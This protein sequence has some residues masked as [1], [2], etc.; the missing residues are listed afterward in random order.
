MTVKRRV[1]AVV[2]ALTMC[3]SLVAGLAPS[4]AAAEHDS[5]C[6]SFEI[7]FYYNSNLGGAKHDYR[8]RISNFAG[9]NFLS[10]GAGAGQ[11]VKNNAASARNYDGYFTA[12]VY[13]N[14]G[15][16]GPADD[17]NILS[18][19]NLGDTYND[20]ASYAWCHQVPLQCITN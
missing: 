12:R 1:G 14:S 15:W 8:Y 16:S 5:V 13:F 18:W 10:P 11:P 6:N 3:G 20:N 9:Y 2:A 7:C 19:R 4:A 17:V